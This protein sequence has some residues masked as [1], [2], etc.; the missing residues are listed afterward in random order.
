MGSITTLRLASIYH[1][2][3]AHVLL[4][5]DFLYKH[6]EYNPAIKTGYILT[7]ASIA[8]NDKV[9]KMR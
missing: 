9:L 7:N 3:A 2:Q 8:T 1:S 6:Q 5:L 4:A